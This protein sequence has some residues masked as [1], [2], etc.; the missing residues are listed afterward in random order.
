MVGCVVVAEGH[1]N[2]FVVLM[3]DDDPIDKPP[4][5][6]KGFF[7][8]YKGNVTPGATA[9]LTF[10]EGRNIFRYLVIQNEFTRKR[11]I[12]L[13]EVQVYVRGMYAVTISLC[14]SKSVQLTAFM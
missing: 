4:E 13:A 1:I 7:V 11:A 6:K 14:L 5:Y 9:N 2:D 10:P 12:C 3:T 8:Q